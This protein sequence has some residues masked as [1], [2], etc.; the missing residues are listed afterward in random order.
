MEVGWESARDPNK[1]VSRQCITLA[2][3]PIEAAHQPPKPWCMLTLSPHM[4]ATPAYRIGFQFSAENLQAS[5]SRLHYS[6]VLSESVSNRHDTQISILFNQRIQWTHTIIVHVLR[7]V[8]SD[9]RVSCRNTS[10]DQF[11]GDIFGGAIKNMRIN[12]RIWTRDKTQPRIVLHSHSFCYHFHFYFYF[13]E[14]KWFFF[15]SSRQIF[16]NCFRVDVMAWSD[17]RS[18]FRITH[19]PPPL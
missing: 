2:F 3:V 8:T 19:P 6:M 15:F 13:W 4:H 14:L 18:W 11:N 16:F 7:F 12:R 17:P 5:K 1:L 10:I 9:R